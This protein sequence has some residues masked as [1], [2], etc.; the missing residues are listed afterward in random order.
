MRLVTVCVALI[1]VSLCVGAEPI[2]TGTLLTEMTDLMRLTLFPDP[3]YKTVQFSS[4]DHQSNLPGGPNWFANSDGFGGEP[5]PNFEAVLKPPG[6]DGIGEYLVCDVKGP[7]AVVREWTARIEGS[8][9]MYLDNRAEPVYDGTAEEFFTNPYARFT[10]AAGIEDAVLQGTFYQ[11]C[12]AYCPFPFAKRCRIVW[13]GNLKRIHF[14]QLQVRVYDKGAKVKTFRPD[15]LAVYPNILRRAARILAN[16]GAEWPYASKAAPAPFDVTVEPGQ[17]VEALALEGPRAIERLTI[18]VAAKDQTLALRQ[19]VFHV[20]CDDY[21]WGQV[22][23]PVGDFFGAAPGINPYDSVP[24][25]VA[26]DGTMTCRFVMP[27]ARK[28]QIVF[29]NLGEQ[30]ITVHGEALLVE[31]AWDAARS[32]H[33][34]A[35]WRV[36]HGLVGSGASVQDLPFLIANGAGTYVGTAAYILNPNNVPSSGGNWWGEGDEKVFSDDDTRPSTFGTG[37]EDYFNYAWSSSEIFLYPY[38]GQPRN[39]GPA[40]RG[41]VANY[42]WH[43]LDA[44]PF[45]YRLSFYMELFPHETNPGMAYARIGYHYARPGL[46]DDHLAIKP[47]DVRPQ[48]LPPAWMPEAR[49]GAHDSVFYQTEDIVQGKPRSAQGEDPMWAGGKLYRWL[50]DAVGAELTCRVPIAEDGKYVLRP[51][52]VLDSASGRVSLY[53]DGQNA[54][55]GGEAGIADLYDAHR[56]LLRALDSRPIELRQG[57]HVI[58][59]KYEGRRAESGDNSIAIDFLW[60]QQLE[61]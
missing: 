23:A 8:I 42:R 48:A 10:K 44:L 58:T 61:K 17:R 54:Q 38:C 60:V 6:A 2:T 19:T 37:S 5:V 13:I 51:V 21:P 32:M 18:N 22:Q 40:N 52:V 57:E 50:P 20:V 7:G 14:Y 47:E 59:F 43:V 25:S 1:G 9:R 41:F 3:A 31:Y 26:P 49:G 4:Y 29:E 36:D 46:M 56:V 35:R 28:A 12:A 11:R 30:S 33:F 16:P 53:V 34:R 55:L 39:D 27:F 45:K 24:F 15:D